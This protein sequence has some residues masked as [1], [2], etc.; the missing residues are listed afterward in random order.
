MFIIRALMCLG[1]LFCFLGIFHVVFSAVSQEF[2]VIVN[3]SSSSSPKSSIL[4]VSG[5]NLGSTFVPTTTASCFHKLYLVS[6]F[7]SHSITCKNT[8]N[9]ICCLYLTSCHL[10]A[11]SMNSISS[12]APL[13]N[14]CCSNK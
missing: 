11:S 3:V 12:T 13:F 14:F 10:L 2:V 7:F 6:A 5:S 8:Y 4:S 9:I 1:R